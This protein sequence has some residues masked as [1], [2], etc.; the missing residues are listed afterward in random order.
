MSPRDQ[1]IVDAYARGATGHEI[2]P[3]FS[4]SP[5]RI[6]Q[7]LAVA[8]RLGLVKM[9]PSATISDEARK[10]SRERIQLLASVRLLE[11]DRARNDAISE[12]V[13]QGGSYNRVGVLF[14]VSRNVVAGVCH[15][16]RQRQARPL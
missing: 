9:R 15:R 6:Y 11:R 7:I 8:V 16:D 1:A 10:R 3:T 2:A 14:G 13:A 5:Q 4:V 12:A